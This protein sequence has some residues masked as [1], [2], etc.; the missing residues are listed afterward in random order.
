MEVAEEDMQGY[1]FY[2]FREMA[3]ITT[4][5]NPFR[6]EPENG[7]V[8]AIDSHLHGLIP[9]LRRNCIVNEV[10]AK[11]IGEQAPVRQ[12]S[13]EDSVRAVWE[14]SVTVPVSIGSE[15]CKENRF[16]GRNMHTSIHS[17]QQTCW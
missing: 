14:K 6:D 9:F 4:E 10:G 13:E 5:L 3:I 16:K 2:V 11:N 15:S 7:E 17:S 8:D 1:I 12:R